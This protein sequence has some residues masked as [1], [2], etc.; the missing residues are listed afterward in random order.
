MVINMKS[1]DLARNALM[2]TILATLV[3]CPLNS[4][5]QTCP[6]DCH[7]MSEEKANMTFGE[8]NYKLCRSEPC[9][10]EQS[11][12]NDAIIPMYCI[13]SSCTQGCFCLTQEQAKQINYEPCSNHLTT[14]G[15][16]SIN[17]PKYCFS[18]PYDCPE[19]CLCLTEL[20]A[21]V[22]GFADLCQDQR[23]ECG[24]FGEVKYCFKVP[25]YDC[26]TGCNCLNQSEAAAKNLTK[27]CLDQAKIPILC[28]IIDAE[29]GLFKFCYRQSNLGNNTSNAFM[30]GA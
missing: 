19:G 21:E 7:C 2:T 23:I 8:G 26:P 13:N 30:A 5:S 16:N 4:S 18:P 15:S 10:T 1:M 20:E 29:K 24:H 3:L 12:I 22:Y 17:T 14:C 25:K 11:A 9:G 27:M 28:E 6:N